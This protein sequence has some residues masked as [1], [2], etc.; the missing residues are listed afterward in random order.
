[1]AKPATSATSSSMANTASTSSSMANTAS[2]SS[3][4]A[5]TDTTSRMGS[6]SRCAATTSGV[7]NTSSV[8]FL[9]IGT[10]VKAILSNPKGCQQGPAI[11]Q[12]V[13][14]IPWPIEA[15]FQV[16]LEPKVQGRACG[17]WCFRCTHHTLVRSIHPCWSTA[18]AVR[19]RV[20]FTQNMPC[21]E[22]VER[23]SETQIC[24]PP[25]PQRPQRWAST[26]PSAAGPNK[27]TA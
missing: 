26:A 1:M 22:E 25:S 7:G 27:T 20:C 19:S 11:R 14:L 21:S 13:F 15:N 10:R 23:R 16:S 2:T 18:T 24:K 5:N 12:S 8:Q 17:C 9:Q 6:S 4:M 3:S